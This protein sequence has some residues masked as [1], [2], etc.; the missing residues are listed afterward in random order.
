[1]GAPTQDRKPRPIGIVTLKNR[2]LNPAAQLFINCAREVVKT[3][4]AK[5]APAFRTASVA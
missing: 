4:S 5:E 1:M 3:P 2:T